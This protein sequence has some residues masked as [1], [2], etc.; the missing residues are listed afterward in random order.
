MDSKNNIQLSITIII[1]IAA[2]FFWT[3]GCRLGEHWMDWFFGL[4]NWPVG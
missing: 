1:V 2:G 4:L 3:V